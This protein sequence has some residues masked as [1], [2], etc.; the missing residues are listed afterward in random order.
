MNEN[1]NQV[2]EMENFDFQV[3][4]DFMLGLPQQGPGSAATTQRAWNGFV[5]PN[6]PNQELCVADMGCGSGHQTET[7][8]K[9][10]PNGSSIIA[11][12]IAPEMLA[13]TSNR[14]SSVHNIELKTVTGSMIDCNEICANTLNL[15]WAEGSIYHVGYEL[16]LQKWRN[17]L[18]PNGLVALTECVLKPTTEPL[19]HQL[20]EWLHQNFIE[21]ATAE[22]KVE[23]MKKCGYN[24]LGHFTLPNNCWTENY[25]APMRNRLQNFLSE[26]PNN[27]TAQ[28]LV[29]GLKSEIEMFEKY[30]RFY[31]YEFIVGQ[32]KNSE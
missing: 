26:K 22:S 7:L 11:V 25:Y 9:L 13:A 28:L 3:I 31:G 8:S 21:I 32:V 23:T 30:N 17:Y 6:L 14:L 27:Q 4:V 29:E 10:L 15:I 19:P 20:D 24:V 2:A 16:G 12:D 5:K 1:E 18:A